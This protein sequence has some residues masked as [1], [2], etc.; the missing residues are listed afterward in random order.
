M[1]VSDDLLCKIIVSDLQSQQQGDAGCGCR[2]GEVK[3]RTGHQR[4][5]HERRNWNCRVRAHG[6]NFIRIGG[7][8]FYL[9]FLCVIVLL[10]KIQLFLYLALP[11]I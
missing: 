11:F 8:N 9:I 7:C 5:V 2:N 6:A 10:L 4:E 1:V 3:P